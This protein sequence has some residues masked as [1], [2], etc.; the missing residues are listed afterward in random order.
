[1]FRF[2][3]QPSLGCALLVCVGSLAVVF[4]LAGALPA[5]E[6]TYL[7]E[8]QDV[9]FNPDNGMGSV[10]MRVSIVEDDTTDAYPTDTNGFSLGFAC[11][12]EYLTPVEISIAGALLEL[13]DSDGPWIAL[14]D[15]DA[16][17]LGFTA[18]VVYSM[19]LDETLVLEGEV[20]DAIFELNAD[21]LIDATTD[22]EVDVFF[23]EDL[24][25]APKDPD[26]AADDPLTVKNRVIAGDSPSRP[27]PGQRSRRPLPR[28]SW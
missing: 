8:D 5:Q 22:I 18:G 24:V 17:E 25:G 2:A 26:E 27:F 7:L 4:L 23:T 14:I 12:T 16:D 3:M 13:D 21:T 9:R 19:M 28:Q 20:L 15:I 11:D 6:F 10:A 1:M